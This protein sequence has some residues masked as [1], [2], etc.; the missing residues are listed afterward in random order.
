MNILIADDEIISH[1][2]Y[3][4][5]FDKNKFDILFVDIDFPL[6]RLGDAYLMYAELAARGQGS[7]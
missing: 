1:F 5:I 4:E 6:F 3:Q 7:T 2:F